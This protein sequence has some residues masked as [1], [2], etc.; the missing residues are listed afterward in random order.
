LI[1]KNVAK[2]QK[3]LKKMTLSEFKT[4]LNAVE[5]LDFQLPDGSLVPA[6]FHVTEVGEINKRFVDCGGTVRKESKINFQLWEAYD[7]DHQLKPE[8]LKKIIELSEK[9]LALNDLEIE[10]EYQSGTIGKF[11]LEF[12]GQQFQLTSTK[13]NCLA[14]ESCG[15]PNDK[16]K[17]NLNGVILNNSANSC[18]PSGGCC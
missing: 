18:S 5:H 13:T 6:H 1:Q 11:G 16:L 3:K 17:I 15:I 7:F 9:Q 8:K 2:H 14:L 10:V 12:N 4:K